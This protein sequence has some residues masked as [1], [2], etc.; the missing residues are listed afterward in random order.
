LAVAGW[1]ALLW[2]EAITS[3]YLGFAGIHSF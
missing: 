2:G 1:I 3:G